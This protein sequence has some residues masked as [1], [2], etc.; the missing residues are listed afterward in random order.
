MKGRLPDFI[1]SFLED[2][3][4]QARTGRSSRSHTFNRVIEREIKRYYKDR[5]FFVR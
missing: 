3:T 1:K 2:R 4:I 5:W